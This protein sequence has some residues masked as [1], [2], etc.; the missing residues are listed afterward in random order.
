MHAIV[1]DFIHCQHQFSATEAVDDTEVMETDAN[2][3]EDVDEARTIKETIESTD[4][5]IYVE[6]P[7][8]R[9]DVQSTNNRTFLNYGRRGK[10]CRICLEVM[11]DTQTSLFSPLNANIRINEALAICCGLEI[12]QSHSSTVNEICS[13]CIEQL[14]AA[15]N[16][17]RLCWTSQ[18][19]LNVSRKQDDRNDA[20]AKPSHGV[21]R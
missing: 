3:T 15:Y 14:Q 9:I 7:N 6:A 13:D 16:F 11:G 10:C 4:S 20:T 8:D 18:F 2:E 17:R 5:A 12:F 19:E 1:T 21:S